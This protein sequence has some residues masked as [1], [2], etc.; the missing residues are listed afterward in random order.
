MIRRGVKGFQL[1]DGIVEDVI[2]HAPATRFTYHDDPIAVS[3]ASGLLYRRAKLALMNILMKPNLPLQMRQ[4]LYRTARVAA[5]DIAK[6]KKSATMNVTFEKRIVGMPRQLGFE[7]GNHSASIVVRI[8]M[9]GK[10]DR[11]PE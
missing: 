3:Y 2:E 7:Q 8:D 11:P 1:G 4:D 5:A 9:D 6:G 10:I